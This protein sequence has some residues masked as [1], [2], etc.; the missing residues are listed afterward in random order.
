MANSIN[1]DKKRRRLYVGYLEKRVMLKN[2]INDN[3]KENYERFNAQLELQK[4]PRNSLKV[5]L[6]KRCV[7]TGRGQ[8]LVGLFNISRIKLRELVSNGQIPGLK[9][10]VW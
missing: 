1:I 9:K 6:K 8:G 5:R 10:A 7:L 3:T 2:I 4:I